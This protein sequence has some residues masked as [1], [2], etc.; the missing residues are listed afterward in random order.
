MKFA[1]LLVL[2]ILLILT[3][4]S[5]FGSNSA[6]AEESLICSEVWSKKNIFRED[7]EQAKIIF[8]IKE[9]GTKWTSA[10]NL[11]LKNSLKD[12]SDYELTTNLK[13]NYIEQRN[14]ALTQ[15]IIADLF[16]KYYAVNNACA[17]FGNTPNL[18]V[19]VAELESDYVNLK[20]SITDLWALNG[21][22]S[23]LLGFE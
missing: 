19:E 5:S 18:K 4:C 15:S 2:P 23:S 20:Y 11:E 16:F 12:I 21:L 3:G 7:G 9:L 1:R 13:K 10:S 8:A 22:P 17:N 6:S 14:V